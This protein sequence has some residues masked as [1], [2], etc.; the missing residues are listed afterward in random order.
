MWSSRIILILL[1]LVISIFGQA[2]IVLYNED[3]Q[4][5]NSQGAIGNS[6]GQAIVNVSAVDWSLDISQCNLTANT[7]WFQVR[8]DLLEARDLDGEAFWL[9]PPINIQGHLQC[10]LKLKVSEQGVLESSDY[11]ITEYRIDGGPWLQAQRNGALYNDFGSLWVEHFGIAGNQLEIRVRLKNNADSEYLKLDSISVIGYQELVYSGG[12][13]NYIPDEYTSGI[14]AR[15]SG[16]ESLSISQAAHLKSLNVENTANLALLA[17]AKLT[18][19]EDIL[20]DGL[21]EL[22]SGASLVQTSSSNGNQGTGTYKVYQDYLAQDHQR[23]NLWSS[24]VQGADIQTVFA[25][26]NS[27][28]R[29]RFEANSQ[30]YQSYSN[31]TMI[32]G[33]GYACTPTIQTSNLQTAFQ[34]QRVFQGS[35]NNGSLSLQILGIKA[36]DWLLLGNP[37]PSTMDFQAFSAGNPDLE[38]TLYLWDASPISSLAS[39]FALWNATGAVPLP[40]SQKASPSDKVAPMQ[41]FMVQI[42]SSFNDTLIDISFNNAMRSASNAG[43]TFYKSKESSRDR[44]WFSLAD[45]LSARAILVSLGDDCPKQNRARLLPSGLGMEFFSLDQDSKP[46][47]I[48]QFYKSKSPLCIPIGVDA[49]HEGTHTIALDSIN[50]ITI[51]QVLLQDLENDSTVDLL[52]RAYTFKAQTGEDLR[53]FQIIIGDYRNHLNRQAPLASSFN[54]GKEGEYWSLNFQDGLK[55]WGLRNSS[56]GLIEEEKNVNQGDQKQYW[57]Q[58]GLPTGLLILQLHFWDGGSEAVKFINSY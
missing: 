1:F 22:N 9:S 10:A 35:I 40:L 14:G 32:P 36:G 19:T 56:G 45:S 4:S 43:T 47:Q 55:S 27:N 50:S 42:K 5:Q 3:F 25:S 8:N 28:D 58:E 13:W 41:A 6:G 17:G 34:D 23:F 53:R 51:H 15:I 48:Q 33:R 7:D 30:S 18:I 16:G 57:H 38:T 54:F 49:S 11:L 20:N 46:C 52:E 24:P 37:Y 12:S 44:F 26:S 39:G 21:I 29:Y 31:G 2:Q